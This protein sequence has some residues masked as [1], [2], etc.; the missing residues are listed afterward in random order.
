V[1]EADGSFGNDPFQAQAGA[2]SKPVGGI[3]VEDRDGLPPVCLQ[4]EAFQ[5]QMALA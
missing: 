1:V 5:Q 3:A 2:D 4:G